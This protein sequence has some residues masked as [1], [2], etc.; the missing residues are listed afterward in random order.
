VSAPLSGVEG[1]KYDTTMN[2]HHYL[3]QELYSNAAKGC[4]AG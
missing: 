2:G 4:V 1:A 3:L